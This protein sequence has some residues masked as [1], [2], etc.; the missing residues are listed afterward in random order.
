MSRH[1]PGLTWYDM[2]FSC[3]TRCCD[4]AKDKGQDY[5]DFTDL[6]SYYAGAR[7]KASHAF[8][9]DIQDLEKKFSQEL[10]EVLLRMPQ[11]IK[12]TTALGTSHTIKVFKNNRSD[13]V[14]SNVYRFTEVCCRRNIPHCINP[15]NKLDKERLLDSVP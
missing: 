9:G 5:T 11:G 12:I 4:A 8:G 13:S 15:P 2:L 14:P 10:L 7:R 6:P 3:L 1:M